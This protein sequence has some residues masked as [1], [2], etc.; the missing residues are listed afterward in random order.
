LFFCPGVF[1]LFGGRLIIFF[2]PFRHKL[3]KYS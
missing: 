3:K 2:W 1:F